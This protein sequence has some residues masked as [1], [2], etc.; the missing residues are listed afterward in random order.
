MIKTVGETMK[1]KPSGGIRS[2]ETAVGYLKQGADR[3]GVG[4]TEKVLEG[5]ADNGDRTDY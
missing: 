3:L 4:S 5:S 2:W 1:I